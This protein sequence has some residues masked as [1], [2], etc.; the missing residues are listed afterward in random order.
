MI[1]IAEDSVR[2]AHSGPSQ[3]FLRGLRPLVSVGPLLFWSQCLRRRNS[4]S[5]IAPWQMVPGGPSHFVGPSFREPMPTPGKELVHDCSVTDGAGRAF[6][7]RGSLPFS[8]ANASR[9]H[10]PRSIADKH[11]HFNHSDPSLN[12]LRH[13]DP[14]YRYKRKS[15]PESR[16]DFPVGLFCR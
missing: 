2:F 16:I 10:L 12:L 14:G 13:G 4:R 7:L 8:G 5:M 9:H 11:L 15:R 1:G 3:R 6:P